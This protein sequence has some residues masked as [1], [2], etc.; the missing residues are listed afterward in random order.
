MNN[1]GTSKYFIGC[2]V[3]TASARNWIVLGFLCLFPGFLWM[4]MDTPSSSV[5]ADEFNGCPIF[6]VIYGV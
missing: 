5:L 6:G 1:F 4:H 2:L 3:C